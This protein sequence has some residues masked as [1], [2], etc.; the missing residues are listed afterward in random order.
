MSDDERRDEER[1]REERQREEDERRQKERAKDDDLYHEGVRTGDYSRWLAPRGYVPPA[2]SIERSESSE[3]EGATDEDADAEPVTGEKVD[4]QAWREEAREG[5]RL[6]QQAVWQT[7]LSLTSSQ[8][9]P[10]ERTYLHQLVSVTNIDG[11]DADGA[12]TIDE[13]IRVADTNYRFAS[14]VKDLRYLKSTL[15]SYRRVKAIDEAE[16]SAR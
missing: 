2:D 4:A 6:A 1:R 16:R 5:V 11:D 13:F 15:E 3:A 9:G 8:N 7:I 10:Q 12:S 14:L